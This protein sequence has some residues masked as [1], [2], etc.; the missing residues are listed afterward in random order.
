MGKQVLNINV[1]CLDQ[2]T[3]ATSHEPSDWL[4]TP[5]NY[6]ADHRTLGSHRWFWR[7]LL[8]YSYFSSNLITSLPLTFPL[9]PL[10]LPS[11][12]WISILSVWP[13]ETKCKQVRDFLKKC[14]IRCF[15]R[16]VK[17]YGTHHVF[18]RVFT[19]VQN[20]V[21]QD[22]DKLYQPDII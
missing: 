3:S 21:L 2:L 1:S 18:A 22:K 20:R 4:V 11:C 9:F 15:S 16:S 13:P 7:I 19:K 14:K 10:H 5:S 6:G 17:R 12:S 8:K